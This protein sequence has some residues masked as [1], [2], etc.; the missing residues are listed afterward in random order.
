MICC[1]YYCTKR[2]PDLWGSLGLPLRVSVACISSA[3]QDT[4]WETNPWLV[5]VAPSPK[6]PSY[7]CAMLQ[8]I[9]AMDGADAYAA[10]EEDTW[11]DLVFLDYNLE[12]GDSGVTV[13][14]APF[15]SSLLLL[16]CWPVPLPRDRLGWF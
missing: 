6:R 1:T 5:S 13:S 11:P 4:F 2:I 14:Q 9:T 10:L 8:I 3:Q 16:L 7:S 12:V 15:L